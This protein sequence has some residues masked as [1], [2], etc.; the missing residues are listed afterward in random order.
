MLLYSTSRQNYASKENATNKQN[1]TSKPNATKEEN[2]ASISIVRPKRDNMGVYSDYYHDHI[3]YNYY[4]YKDTEDYR[5]TE[6]ASYISV[7]PAELDKYEVMFMRWKPTPFDPT[8]KRAYGTRM[9]KLKRYRL[10]LMKK[11]GQKSY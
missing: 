3:E 2:I 7:D 11:F 1:A 5:Y 9:G 4:M 6:H 10:A 8:R